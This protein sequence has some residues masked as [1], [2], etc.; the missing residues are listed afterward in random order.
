[1]KSVKR[2]KTTKLTF[3]QNVN[4]KILEYT[5]F[6]N[7]FRRHIRPRKSVEVWLKE[8]ISNIELCSNIFYQDKKTTWPHQYNSFRLIQTRLT[9]KFAK[10]PRQRDTGSHVERG[11]KGQSLAKNLLRLTNVKF[12]S[13]L[14][15]SPN[16]KLLKN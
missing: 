11:E 9:A 13:L 10:M 5:Q 6:R 16:I 8:D 14:N 2:V 4:Y 15:Q 1:M 3:K 12:N 7:Y